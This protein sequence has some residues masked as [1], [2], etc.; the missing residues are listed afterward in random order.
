MK[1]LRNHARTRCLSIIN[2][3]A[4]EDARD[5]KIVEGTPKVDP[6]SSSMSSIYR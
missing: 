2:T 5:D 6:P 4:S 1:S 3:M